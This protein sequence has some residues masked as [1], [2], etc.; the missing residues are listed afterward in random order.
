MKRH[1]QRWGLLVVALVA[2]WLVLRPGVAQAQFENDDLEDGWVL[3]A[4]GAITAE[5]LPFPVGTPLIAVGRF[6]FDG[7]GECTVIDQLNIGGTI[8]PDPG[9][10]RTSEGDGA[11]T[12]TVNEDGTGFLAATFGPSQPLPGTIELTFALVSD[13]VL[14]FIT[15]NTPGFSASGS[16]EKQDE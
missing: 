6:T 9:S 3:S 16:L 4:S 7:E 10:F 13:E 15:T 8:F 11:C 5:G 14:R 1:S 2:S 12:Y